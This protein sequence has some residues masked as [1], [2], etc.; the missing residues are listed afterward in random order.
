MKSAARG[1]PQPF[2]V[3]VNSKLALFEF[4]ATWN[5]CGAFSEASAQSG[6]IEKRAAKI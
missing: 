3:A 4:T 6:E 1:A 5:G 2:Q